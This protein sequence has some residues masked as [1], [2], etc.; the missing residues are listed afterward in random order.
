MP[1]QKGMLSG[2]RRDFLRA[3]MYGVGVSAGLPALLRQLSQARTAKGWTAPRSRTPGAS[4]SSW[5]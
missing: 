5:S 2:S 3:G 4:W 1:I